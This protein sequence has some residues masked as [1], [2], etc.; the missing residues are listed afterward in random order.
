LDLL[1]ELLDP[2]KP[3]DW[4]PAACGENCDWLTPNSEE[5]MGFFIALSA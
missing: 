2:L 4:W 3:L 5:R 1:L